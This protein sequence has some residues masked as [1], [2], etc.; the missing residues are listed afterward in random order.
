MQATN[1]IFLSGKNFL[2]LSLLQIE[3]AELVF[4]FGLSG[5]VLILHGKDVLIDWYFILQE[6]IQLVYTLTLQNLLVLQQF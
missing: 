5:I 3:C 4:Q 1:L 2:S 6:I